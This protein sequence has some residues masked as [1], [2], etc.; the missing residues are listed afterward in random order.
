VQDLINEIRYRKDG[1][2]GYRNYDDPHRR[3]NSLELT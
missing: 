3:W 2:H 1:Q